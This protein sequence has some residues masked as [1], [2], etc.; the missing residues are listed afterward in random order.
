VSGN[1]CAITMAQA[2]T[3]SVTF[4]AVKYTLTISPV[5]NKGVITGPG[6]RCGQPSADCTEAFPAGSVV[7]LTA[8]PPKRQRVETWAGCDSVS[9]TSC[10]VT[11][12]QARTVSAN[13][14]PR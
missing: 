13:F 6:L 2:R 4:V 7:V 11:M 3:V 9:G 1:Q 12:S 10:T 14:A 5:P 8:S